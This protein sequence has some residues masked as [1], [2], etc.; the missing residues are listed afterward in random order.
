MN[1]DQINGFESSEDH[2]EKPDPELGKKASG[3]FTRGKVSLPFNLSDP[4]FPELLEGSDGWSWW[5]EDREGCS[6]ALDVIKMIYKHGEEI[7]TLPKLSKIIIKIS[8]RNSIL[9]N[10]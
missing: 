7:K 3:K 10:F 6:F 8:P 9:F 1:G 2:G 4:L 5:E